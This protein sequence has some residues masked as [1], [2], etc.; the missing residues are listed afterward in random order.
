[1]KKQIAGA[2]KDN[3]WE[4]QLQIDELTRELKRSQEECELIKHKLKGYKNKH[5]SDACSNCASMLTKLEE[6][7]SSVR[8]RDAFIVDLLSLMRKLN[9]NQ[10]SLRDELIKLACS[11]KSYNNSGVGGGGGSDFVNKLVLDF[12]SGNELKKKDSSKFTNKKI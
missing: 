6:S 5:A 11:N 9:P 1:L 8:E 2:F 7:V 12:N 3:S 4:R 10:I